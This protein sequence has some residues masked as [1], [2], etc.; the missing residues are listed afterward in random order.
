MVCA[1]LGLEAD[2]NLSEYVWVRGVCGHDLPIAYLA[3]RQ[4]CFIPLRTRV[5]AAMVAF[6]VADVSSGVWFR[7]IRDLLGLA[8]E[9]EGEGESF[10]E[11]LQP[12]FIVS[13]RSL[14]LCGGIGKTSFQ[15]VRATQLPPE[16]AG[17]LIQ[18]C[19]GVWQDFGLNKHSRKNMLICITM[20]EG[21]LSCHCSGH[22]RRLPSSARTPRLVRSVFPPSLVSQVSSQL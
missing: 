19:A 12:Q 21:P 5:S 4:F 20:L 22:S 17:F 16:Q 11:G 10:P 2:V 7:E 9:G 3:Q 18:A 14:Y 6:P 1:I 8:P 13:G 15:K